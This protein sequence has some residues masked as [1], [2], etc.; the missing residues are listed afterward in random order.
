[1]VIDFILILIFIVLAVA[2]VVFLLRNDRGE[3]KPVSALW[4][5]AGFGF[6]GAIA[7]AFIEKELYTLKCY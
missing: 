4:V 3:K 1:M 2:L 5:A 7:A 6:L